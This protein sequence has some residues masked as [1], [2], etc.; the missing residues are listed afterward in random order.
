MGHAF[1]GLGREREAREAWN[2]AL[3]ASRQLVDGPG[4]AEFRP[5]LAEA[6]VVLDRADEARREL[7]NL[8]D[9]GYGDPY[10]LELATER[11][12]IP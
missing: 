12:I 2:R 10:L 4:G 11:G 7:E 6:Y 5:M 1:F 8:K 9:Q 3:T